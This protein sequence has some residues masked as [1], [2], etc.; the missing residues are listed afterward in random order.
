[1]RLPSPVPEFPVSDLQAS[2]RF[3][4]QRMGFR[5]DWTY[6]DELAGI[7]KDATRIFLRR[8]SAADE[9]HGANVLVW[10]NL[11]SPAEVDELHEE[12]KRNGVRI[13]D[14]PRTWDLREFTAQDPDGNRF[15]VFHDLGASRKAID[16]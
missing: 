15:R 4:E 1:M 16:A 8:R 5:I 12:W 2:S 14:G 13:V 11:A 10:L 3:Y 6:T 7:S 9:E